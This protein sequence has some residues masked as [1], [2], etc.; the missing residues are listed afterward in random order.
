MR[1]SKLSQEPVSNA[2]K[3]EPV[4]RQTLSMIRQAANRV[5]GASCR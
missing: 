5:T 3:G 1:E 4:R 2:I